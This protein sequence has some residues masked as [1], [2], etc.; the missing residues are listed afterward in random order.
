MADFECH[1]TV[2]KEQ[3]ALAAVTANAH[4]FKM[5]NITDDPILGPGA[6]SYCTAHSQ[7]FPGLY[8][9]MK[10]LREAL[11]ADNI[12]VLRCK[13]EAI[14]FDEVYEVKTK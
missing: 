11:I 8:T 5:S 1:I 14:L 10:R 4:G 9:R 7:T 12:P 2:S 3:H 6:K 13:I